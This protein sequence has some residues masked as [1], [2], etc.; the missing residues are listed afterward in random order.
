MKSIARKCLAGL[1]LLA[2]LAAPILLTAQQQ[3]EGSTSVDT[4]TANPVPLINQPLVPDA[5]RPHGPGFTLTVNGTG[6]VSTSVVKWNGSART[7]TFVSKSQLK[8]NI[9]ALDI[10]LASTASVTVVNPSPGGGT[11]NVVFFEV[12]I[13]TSAIVLAKSGFGA[14]V[15]PASVAV[16]DFNGDGKLDLAVANDTAEQREHL[17]GKGDGTFQAAVSYGMG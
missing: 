11:S 5:T 12:T 10:A 16:G 17:L 4:G 15:A 14:G 8:A 6:F 13:A 9:L 1:M 3:P 7:T 2:A